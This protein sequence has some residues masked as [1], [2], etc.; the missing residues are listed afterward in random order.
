[1][2]VRGRSLQ[3]KVCEKK[4]D[5][6][7]R[8][9]PSYLV[10]GCPEQESNLHVRT[11]TTP[12]IERVCRFRHPGNCTIKMGRQIYARPAQSKRFWPQKTVS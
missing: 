3:Q 7:E 11:D 5:G 12:A 6:E 10:S 2:G 8:S 4:N 1:M 9:S